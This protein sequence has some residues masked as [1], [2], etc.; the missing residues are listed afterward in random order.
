MALESKAN[1]AVDM[2]F[3]EKRAYQ[4]GLRRV[5]GIDEVGRGPLAG[6]VV[7]AAVI[8]PPGL[9]LPGVKD[10]KM[11]SAAQ[12]EDLSA[13]ILRSAIAV[14]IGCVSEAEID[15]I[16]ILKASF[17][18]ML[19]AVRE[20]S[21]PPD[22]LLIDGPYALPVMIAQ[23]GI[24][25]GDQL[26]LSIAAASIV[27]KVHRDRIM[28]EYHLTYPEYGFDRHKGYATK[29]HL[30]SLHKHGACP[31]HRAS[32]RGVGPETVDEGLT[33]GGFTAEERQAGRTPRRGIP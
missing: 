15:Q 2:L 33:T 6:P 30:E 25:R 1:P 31:I 16:N 29:A 4:Q 10:S 32:F 9:E 27:A 28:S 26:S 18:A 13:K 23:Q 22:F 7:A 3:Y 8:L 24:P 20:I 11:L 19:M 5:A 12:R 14:G 21:P 17:L